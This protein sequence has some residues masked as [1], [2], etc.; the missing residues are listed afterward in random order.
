MTHGK[1]TCNYLKAIRRNIAQ[2]NEIELEI[3][4][5][6]YKGECLGTCP[7]CEA[8]VRFLETG[9]ARRSSLGK[10]ATIAGIAV[11]L[12]SPVAAQVKE[13]DNSHKANTQA[14]TATPNFNP[15]DTIRLQGLAPRRTRVPYTTY[16]LRG[17]IIDKKTD[18]EIPFTNIRVLDKEGKTLVGTQSD[19]DGQF[20]FK[21]LPQGAAKIQISVMGYHPTEMVLSDD[22]KNNQ[23]IIIKM[24]CK[25]LVL[26]GIMVTEDITP[27]I[28]I[29]AP[30]ISQTI[31]RDGLKV[32]V[33]Y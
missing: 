31:E 9:L 6:T 22:L 19:M 16:A 10:A 12:A 20:A 18:E 13:C 25:A 15:Q 23:P 4:E 27:V 26:E 21:T 30:S 5:C 14:A 29:G 3:P 7:Q 1:D 11:T 8:E 24:E 17:K 33:I 2:E 32:K 28:D